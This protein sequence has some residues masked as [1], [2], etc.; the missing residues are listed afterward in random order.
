MS[1]LVSTQALY[2]FL[3]LDV[4]AY[5]CR[6]QVPFTLSCGTPGRL[7]WV[8][9]NIAR[10]DPSVEWPTDL[11]CTFDWNQDLKTFDGVSS[12]DALAIAYGT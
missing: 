2:G 3:Q 11:A 12:W 4:E 7:R 9:S 1:A 5:L 10:F 8:T 6:L